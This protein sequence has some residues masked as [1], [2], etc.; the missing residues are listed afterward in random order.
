LINEN[1]DLFSKNHHYIMRITGDNPEGKAKLDDFIDPESKYPVIVTTSRLLSTGVDAQTCK[2]IVLD[3]RILSLTEFK[4][5]IGRG[6]RIREDFGKAF[7]TIIDFKKATERFSDPDFDGEP[8]S[9]YDPNPGQSPLPPVDT[10]PPPEPKPPS[11]KYYVNDVEVSL[12]S[13]HVKYLNIEGELITESL[14]DYTRKN[15]FQRYAT[16]NDFLTHWN[17]EKRKEVIVKELEEQG[18]IFDALKDEIGKAY[19]PFDLICHVAF[20]KPPLTRTERAERVKD[21]DYFDQYEEPV[22]KVLNSLLDKY[23]D[24]GLYNLESLESLKL[25]PLNEFGTPI[26]IVETFGGKDMYLDAIADLT[27]HL[28]TET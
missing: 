23:A 21:S 7:F 6:T 3:R 2:V 26:Q 8:I 11:R 13:E 27:S 4:Q 28:Y 17:S 25:Q 16:L 10:P 9:V 22:R 1:A 24:E 12:V 20:D 14:I 15:V 18:I 5:I 19:D